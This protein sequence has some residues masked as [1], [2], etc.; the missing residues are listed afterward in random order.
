MKLE[1]IIPEIKTLTSGVFYRELQ[2]LEDFLV[3]K[4]KQDTI[5]HYKIICTELLYEECKRIGLFFRIEV[6]KSL[7]LPTDTLITCVDFFELLNN[8]TFYVL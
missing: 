4:L 2:E 6:I 8:N 3:E 1:R 5:G 7:N